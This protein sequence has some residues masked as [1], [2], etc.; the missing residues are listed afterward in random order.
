M[1]EKQNGAQEI[2]EL[3]D[4]SPE[5]RVLPYCETGEVISP[6][7]NLIV[8]VRDIEYKKKN[9]KL[10]EYWVKGHTREIEIP[11]ATLTGSDSNGD[12]HIAGA[13]PKAKIIFKDELK[14]KDLVACLQS[15]DKQ[16]LY[17]IYKIARW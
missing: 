5:I 8:K 17:V 6:L 11:M 13:F 14:V 10:D 12:G 1:Q 9:I 15:K 3:F 16:T 2:V 7:P 4:P